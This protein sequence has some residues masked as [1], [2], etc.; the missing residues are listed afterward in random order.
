MGAYCQESSADQK[1]NL[2]QQVGRV[3]AGATGR[4]L[5]VDEVVAE[6]GSGMRGHGR[7]LTKILSD[8]AAT[9]LVMQRRD[10]LA[11]VGFEHLAACRRRVVV[12]DEAET[13]GDL[14]REVTEVLTSRC[15]RRYG[16]RFASRQAARAVVVAT[17]GTPA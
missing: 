13:T 11:R 6:V 12:L 16:R 1:D 8:P 3:L 9:V 15:A 7:R 14:V 10:R 5:A 17:G 2:P 4:G